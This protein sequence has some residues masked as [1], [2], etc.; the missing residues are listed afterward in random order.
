VMVGP[1]TYAVLV[2]MLGRVPTMP[3]LR[4]VVAMIGARAVM[5]ASCLVHGVPLRRVLRR[6]DGAE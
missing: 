3:M 2:M 1:A 4:M 5:V 6:D